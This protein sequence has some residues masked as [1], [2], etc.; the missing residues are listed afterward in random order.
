MALSAQ[1]PGSHA[2]ASTL[3][4]GAPWGVRRRMLMAWGSAVIHVTSCPSAAAMRVTLAAATTW[5]SAA[6]SPA[7]SACLSNQAH[8]V[9]STVPSVWTLSVGS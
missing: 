3:S 1:L 6:G 5:P 9:E 4:S 7:L 8:T 2:N